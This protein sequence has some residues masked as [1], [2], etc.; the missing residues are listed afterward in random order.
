MLSAKDR[1]RLAK[2][3]KNTRYPSGIGKVDRGECPLDYH[4]PSACM[5]CLCGHMLE[6]HYPMSCEEAKCSHYERAV[7]AQY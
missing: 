4:V 3:D 7:Y 6:C 1:E 5:I 2:F